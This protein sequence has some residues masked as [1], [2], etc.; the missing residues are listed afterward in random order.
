MDREAN[1]DTSSQEEG[2][3]SGLWPVKEGTLRREL[4]DPS[5]SI[6]EGS[7]HKQKVV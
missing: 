6:L 3:F 1:V 5:E 4:Q 2:I 7:L